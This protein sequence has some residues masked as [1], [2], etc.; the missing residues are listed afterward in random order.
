MQTDNLNN[1][2]DQNPLD[3]LLA[4]GLSLKRKTR[5]SMESSDRQLEI[6]VCQPPYIGRHR[7]SRNSNRSRGFLETY[8]P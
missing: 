7:D 1:F 5:S 4:P 2:N 8:S 3:F 6:P